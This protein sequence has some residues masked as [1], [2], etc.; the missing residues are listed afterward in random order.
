MIFKTP[1]DYSFLR[2]FG[3]ACYPYLR[4]FTQ[5]KFETRSLPCVFLGYHPQYKGYRCLY[6]PTGRVYISRHVIFGEQTFPFEGQYKHLAVA[7]ATGLH[8]TWQEGTL[9]VPPPV[10]LPTAPLHVSEYPQDNRQVPT[11]HDE[12]SPESTSS[13]TD[14]EVFVRHVSEES[15]EVLPAEPVVEP[16]AEQG[17]R[18]S[19]IT[20]SQ[21]GI[22]KP[23]PRYALVASKTIPSLPQTV[24]EALAHPGWRQAM[25]DELDSIYKNHTWVLTEATTDMNILGCRWVFTVKLNADGTLN[26]LKARLVAKGFNQEEGVDFTET[27]SP[28]VRTSTIRI[29]LAV[30]T[31]KSWSVTQLDVKNAFLHGDLQEEVFMI[32]PPGFEDASKPHHACSLRKALYGLKQA[33]RAWFDKFSRFLLDYGFVCSKADPSLFVY[34]HNGD[35]LV[36]LLYV[37]DILLT[38]SN[39]SQ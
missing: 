24:A 12:A 18:H 15:S 10:Y 29:V 34:H 8:R 14:T 3:A 20:R 25:L 17:P 4:P 30:A 23:N 22:H 11:G 39:A 36:L 35:T 6:P 1:P 16:S 32:Q 21:A 38:G 19:M 28:V 26:K 5:H 37:D 13:D 33:P 27:Y 2:V 9:A 31:S 7:H